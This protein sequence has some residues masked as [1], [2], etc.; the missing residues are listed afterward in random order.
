MVSNEPICKRIIF[1]IETQIKNAIIR[2][3]NKALTE[4]EVEF[5][6]A[7]LLESVFYYL[8][9]GFVPFRLRQVGPDS[10]FFPFV[11]PSHQ[12]ES[13]YEEM[14]FE[15]YAP[16]LR[17]FYSHGLMSGSDS[18]CPRIFTYTFSNQSRSGVL[19]GALPDYR[20]LLQCRQYQ[21]DYTDLNR[22]SL[23]LLQRQSQQNERAAEY[24][25]TNV[26]Q[27]L[28]V[29]DQFRMGMD[30][31]GDYEQSKAVEEEKTKELQ[32]TVEKQAGKNPVIKQFCSSVSLPE[33][34]AGHIVHFKP[35][36][37]DQRV[38]Q[39]IFSEAVLDAL[40]LP[41]DWFQDKGSLPRHVEQ[42]DTARKRSSAGGQSGNGR[43]SICHIFADLSRMM[44]FI[45]TFLKD[46]DSDKKI[47]EAEN[48]KR[49][50]NALD[51]NQRKNQSVNVKNLYLE[52]T[53]KFEIKTS[54]MDSADTIISMYND[55]IIT[56]DEFT[57]TMM[58]ATGMQID[59]LC[60]RLR[61]EKFDAE[62][63]S[64]KMPPPG[65]AAP[66]R[67]KPKTKSEKSGKNET[68]VENETRVK[69]K[70]V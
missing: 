23:L 17:V 56:D 18:K 65:A 47:R 28:S 64:L 54:L 24:G 46:E 4:R 31:S 40:Q 58:Q 45:L 70:N 22:S 10:Q 57:K 27:I 39:Q 21:S 41:R 6:H 20:Q 34:A 12:I 29:P 50:A 33:N 52:T 51:A 53:C 19:K 61:Q 9:F 32:K 43:E 66:P 16:P 14:D 55:F 15:D 67:K 7:F 30:L 36:S 69:N 3:D 26:G 13:E 5:Y 62:I 38:I 68:R 8:A 25:K 2:C 44:S 42:S 48:R 63:K 35:P 49:K 11:V 60:K 1:F 37:I 59:P